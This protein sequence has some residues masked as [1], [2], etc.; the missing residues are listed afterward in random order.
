MS[1]PEQGSNTP[2]SLPEF[3]LL[4]DNA[5]VRLQ[6]LAQA[7]KPWVDSDSHRA[8]EESTIYSYFQKLVLFVMECLKALPL[9]NFPFDHY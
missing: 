5:Y 6:S 8:R 7:L 2:D 4:S 9:A 1:L 3:I